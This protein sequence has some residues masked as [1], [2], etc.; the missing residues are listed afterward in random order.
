MKTL[1]KHILALAAFALALNTCTLAPAQTYQLKNVT[2]PTSTTLDNVTIGDGLTLTSGTLTATATA[3]GGGNQFVYS[4]IV[5]SQAHKVLYVTSTYAAGSAYG[6]AFGNA[7]EINADGANTVLN[8]GYLIGSQTAGFVA[9]FVRPND[10]TPFAASRFILY[11]TASA[12]SWALT[13]NPSI[14]VS[15]NTSF[16]LRPDAYYN[17]VQRNNV[18]MELTY[19]GDSPNAVPYRAILTSATP[20]ALTATG[21]TQ[22]VIFYSSGPTPPPPNAGPAGAIY[23]QYQ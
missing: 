13:F 3:S 18:G 19:Y 23:I 16:V 6:L 17:G 8:I 10:T 1:I 2:A 22:G 4:D 21:T 20:N 15:A 9:G 7:Q 14:T 12:A 5:E 11:G